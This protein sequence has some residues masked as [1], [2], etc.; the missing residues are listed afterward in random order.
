MKKTSGQSEL[1][2]QQLHILTRD[3]KSTLH[4]P[5]NPKRKNDACFWSVILAV[6]SV[7]LKKT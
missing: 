6:M 2:E 5:I 7:F 3:N 4:Q 1:Y